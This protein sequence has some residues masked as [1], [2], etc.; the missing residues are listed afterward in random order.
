MMPTFKLTTCLP[1]NS[2]TYYFGIQQT[3]N[4]PLNIGFDK[5]TNH[6]DAMYY[7]IGSGWTQSS[8]PGSIMINPVMGCYVPP[9]PIGITEY[10]QQHYNFNLYPNPAQNTLTIRTSELTLDPMTVTLY[11]TLG[12]LVLT[13]PFNNAE[14]IDISALP[15][16][17]YVVC[18]NGSSKKNIPQKLIISR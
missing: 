17:V 7:D 8:I 12:E 10:E 9:T 2:G 1:M 3:T 6:H 14:T 15:N 11:S 4:Q 5:N 16:G 18:L 13:Q